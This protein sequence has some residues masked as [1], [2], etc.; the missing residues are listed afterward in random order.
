MILSK[1]VSVSDLNPSR[2]N[3][4]LQ[5][6]E[7]TKLTLD[8][9]YTICK[10]V[11][12]NLVS[13]MQQWIT[14]FEE[15]IHSSS[16]ELNHE[17]AAGLPLSFDH[18]L[19]E[20]L[21]KL[22]QANCTLT[23]EKICEITHYSI[24]QEASTPE[25]I[26]L[27]QLGLPIMYRVVDTTE[28]SLMHASL[29][30]A[31]CYMPGTFFPLPTRSHEEYGRVVELVISTDQHTVIMQI[32]APHLPHTNI[33]NALLFDAIHEEINST[34]MGPR[35]TALNSPDHSFITMSQHN[36][37]TIFTVNELYTLTP[38]NARLTF[39]DRFNQFRHFTSLKR[40]AQRRFFM[41][42]TLATQRS[43]L[44]Y[45]LDQQDRL[46]I[47]LS[48]TALSK[49]NRSILIS[50]ILPQW[51]PDI[52]AICESENGQLA[53]FTPH[54]SSELSI[55]ISMENRA[56]SF[57]DYSSA[58]SFLNV[59]SSELDRFIH[60]SRPINTTPI[61]LDSF[62]QS[63]V[64]TL[65]LSILIHSSPKLIRDGLEMCQNQLIQQA[66][67]HSHHK[68]LQQQP[69]FYAHASIIWLLDHDHHSDAAYI[70]D[71]QPIHQKHIIYIHLSDRHKRSLDTAIK[72]S[73]LR[74]DDFKRDVPSANH[75]A[76]LETYLKTLRERIV[77]EMRLEPLS[78]TIPDSSFKIGDNVA[79][80]IQQWWHTRK[81]QSAISAAQYFYS[82]L[83]LNDTSTLPSDEFIQLIHD[84]STIHATTHILS[85]I[86][87]RLAILLPDESFTLSPELFLSAFLI[88][89]HP[90]DV[91]DHI[92]IEEENLQNAAQNLVKQFD[93]L[94]RFLMD[95]HSF[96]G[97]IQ[98]ITPHTNKS[99]VN[100]L[101][102]RKARQKRESFRR[103]I[104]LRN[105]LDRSEHTRQI[106]FD[107][108]AV[109]LAG[110]RHHYSSYIQ[111]F[112][113]LSSVSDRL[114]LASP[115]YPKS[116]KLSIDT[117]DIQILDDEAK[118][119]QLIQHYHLASPSHPV[120]YSA[121]SEILSIQFNDARQYYVE[122]FNR[123]KTIDKDRI[124]RSMIHS[125]IDIEA[126]LYTLQYKQGPLFD[127]LTKEFT[128]SQVI[129]RN[130]VQQLGG[131]QSIDTLDHMLN[132]FTQQLAQNKWQLV[133]EHVLLHEVAVNPSFHILD[134]IDDDQRILFIRHII[135]TTQQTPPNFD[136]LHQIL[137]E[138]KMKLIRFYRS[139]SD[140]SE[141]I[142]ALMDTDGLLKTFSESLE[143]G[144]IA[145]KTLMYD[146]MRFIQ[147]LE[148]PSR[149]G[150][151]RE[152]LKSMLDGFHRTEDISYQI[153]AGLDFI[154]KKLALI[155]IDSS[156]VFI[157]IIRELPLL[158]LAV[159]ERDHFKSLRDDHHL[160][161]NLTESWVHRTIDSTAKHHL[162]PNQLFGSKRI[163]HIT[164][165]GTL[166]LLFDN[167]P[168][169]KSNLP[170]TYFLD[171]D[172]LINHQTSC[173]SLRYMATCISI[174][175]QFC[176]MAGIGVGDHTLS[177]LKETISP[178][179][180]AIDELD[181]TERASRLT[182]IV[183]SAI[184]DIFRSVGKLYS[185]R[186][187]RENH[188]ILYSNLNELGPISTLI[189]KRI[190]DGLHHYLYHGHV[191]SPK[192]ERT[193]IT[194]IVDE[195]SKL[196]SSVRNM[197]R[198]NIMVHEPILLQLSNAYQFNHLFDRLFELKKPL[199]ND[200]PPLLQSMYSEWIHIRHSVQK[201]ACICTGFAMIRQAIWTENEWLDSS[202][203]YE[204]SL[205]MLL[206]QSSLLQFSTKPNTSIPALIQALI[207]L[208]KT[209]HV[210]SSIS[211]TAQQYEDF[212]NLL[213][214][215]KTGKHH[216]YRLY[217][218]AILDRL[219]SSQPAT[220]TPRI[221]HRD[222]PTQFG[223][224]W[225]KNSHL[226]VSY[227]Q[228]QCHD[229]LKKCLDILP[230]DTSFRHW[231]LPEHMRSGLL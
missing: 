188:T 21:R 184:D 151:T 130:R 87:Q 25:L 160:L 51:Q 18:T 63:C 54:H 226:I 197:I 154:L 164:I 118:T 213:R 212:G 173:L 73:Q 218:H 57:H 101:S 227:I 133:P 120:T 42:C 129:I 46:L 112:E 76:H 152:W 178:I 44:H 163:H 62:I 99:Q 181:K 143:K 150:E 191:L 29:D 119:N 168:L 43:V 79:R 83:N 170:E 228:D 193:D 56:K 9:S 141:E 195:L 165:Y 125:Y 198:F 64:F 66:S 153:A 17:S 210:T 216:G 135:D 111:Q 215:M 224:V 110:S 157:D 58:S 71:R 203:R 15:F 85:K 33:P 159:K 106:Q 109:Q 97:D 95:G 24:P 49:L 122:Q 187:K 22:T 128:N 179:C 36:L 217:K 14:E 186:Q 55:P 161:V 196:A 137:D 231:D 171:S 174:F 229:T 208:L 200:L 189:K 219:R 167:E 45:L 23:I 39:D 136:A 3:L 26:L 123:W 158:Q 156:N 6:A 103:Y 172:R 134:P 108:M 214:K 209:I 176:M 50:N 67:I 10:W 116:P 20:F 12:S 5:S 230:E 221:I 41:S 177:Q 35:R 225:P 162:A 68:W 202:H 199:Q 88:H 185:D 38:D 206:D 138:I 192:L 183:N 30:P 60:L 204:E 155:E 70:F 102:L 211:W 94:C 37:L 82:I 28:L 91:F 31:H 117:P 74:I 2:I 1:K 139:R 222:T 69:T 124:I 77:D 53:L 121:S 11:R 205:E 40:M 113:A 32:L 190:R 4:L 75:S 145:F 147:D 148:A 169:S 131:N 7:S 72:E 98:S 132:E 78:Q 89:F 65:P 86:D 16:C 201:L 114:S 27:Y 207:D 81:S 8:F 166:D 175:R 146:I 48:L 13:N 144:Q 47:G 127:A 34:Y 105:H 84:D 80:S 104:K 93:E 126:H 59:I 149:V 96:N 107:R 220:A 180:N 52:Q 100:G 142:E 115:R 92:G 182:H 61:S 90:N 140:R 19:S 223:S 194:Y